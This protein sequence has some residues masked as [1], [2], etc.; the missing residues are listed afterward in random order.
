MAFNLQCIKKNSLKVYDILLRYTRCSFSELQRLCELASTDLCM[1]LAQLLKENKI[2]QVSE[3][4]GVY[5]RL[6]I[7]IK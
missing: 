5:Y 1:A 4:Q 2:E 7:A 6:A 3:K